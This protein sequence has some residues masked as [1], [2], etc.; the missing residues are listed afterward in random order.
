M[1]N[2]TMRTIGVIS[3]VL[4]I[5]TIGFAAAQA[6]QPIDA[7]LIP[8][9][10]T[11]RPLVSAEPTG[12]LPDRTAAPLPI[13]STKTAPTQAT[14]AQPTDAA[15]SGGGGASSR[16][17]GDSDR[18]VVKRKVRDD[19]HDEDEK[20]KSESDDHDEDKDKVKSESDD[21]D[22]EKKTD[23]DEGPQ[24]TEDQKKPEKQEKTED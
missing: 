21:H 11:D 13:V 18:D 22:D 9:V 7:S 2:T 8:T 6:A 12:A 23:F 20:K 14:H 15:A 1:K 24:K 10:V 5:V 4:F 3:L 19:D 17:S 16:S